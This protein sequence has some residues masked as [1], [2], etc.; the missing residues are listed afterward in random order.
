MPDIYFHDLPVYRVAPKKYQSDLTR[1]INAF[2]DDA[3][4]GLAS[5]LESIKRARDAIGQHWYEKY[6]P[7]QFNEIIGYVRLHFLGSQ[8]RGEYFAVDKKRLV[9]TR[10][11]TLIWR[12]HKLA[13][14]IDIYPGTS[15]A[16]ILARIEEY[17]EDCRKELPGR[18]IDD[19]WVRQVGPYV[20][21]NSLMRSKR[22]SR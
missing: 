1:A 10:T 9:R 16:E 21:W 4:K 11:K 7:W 8:I 3:H 5:R 15:N 12:T 13:P 17:V 14:E 22:V 19:R 2:V 18:F 20:D 6:G